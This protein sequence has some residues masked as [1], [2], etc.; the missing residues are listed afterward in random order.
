M[1]G[2]THSS[3]RW[4]YLYPF[5]SLLSTILPLLSPL[6]SPHLSHLLSP[7]SPPFSLPS[8]PP[9]SPSFSLPSLPPSH[10]PSLSLLSL[11]SLLLSPLVTLLL[12]P[13]SPPFSPS[14]PPLP[15]PLLF[16]LSSLSVTQAD[17][18]HSVMCR[19][20][21]GGPNPL[22]E[23]ETRNIVNYWKRNGPIIGA[24]DWHSYGKL[25]LHPWGE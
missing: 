1:H 21:Y 10:P 2:S 3:S 25:I 7:F 18:V 12:S 8:P 14:I 9:F 23:P 22:S 19:E 16:S 17:T 6:L 15:S 11:L 20:D 5:S 4:H 13:F 24:I